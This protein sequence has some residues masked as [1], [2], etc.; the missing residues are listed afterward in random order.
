MS[1]VNECMVVNLQ[2]GVWQGYRL[3]KEAS[4]EVT[5]QAGAASDAA[6]VNKHLVPKETLKPIITSQG[7]IRLHFYANTL[8]WKDNGDRLLPRRR[9]MTFIQEH[10]ALVD[11]FRAAVE[12]FVSTT[13]L[14]ARDQAEFRMGELFKADDYPPAERL[15]SRFYARLD[16]DPVT[17]AGDFRVQLSQDA[18]DSIRSD[19]E[20]AM[21]ERVSRAIGDVWMRLADTLQHF[22]TKM[23]DE[24]AVF[25]DST[26]HNLREILG[27]L[28]DLNFINDP[29]LERIRGEIEEAIDGLDPKTLRTDKVERK[30]AAAE[31]AR[32][33]EDM[34]GFMTA[35]GGVS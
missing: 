29:N 30:R 1:I 20:R 21:Q 26:V 13:Y 3:D 12:E 2:I 24:D 32:I 33:M 17:E 35:F 15:R 5:Q 23:A 8:P 31:T 27:V 16:I 19:M 28:P 10:G 34:K 4:R 6:R 7:D 22:A 9:Y 11:K 18:A 25:R 14:T